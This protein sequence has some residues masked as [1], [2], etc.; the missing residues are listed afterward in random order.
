MPDLTSLRRS[1]R[2]HRRPLA[3]LLAGR[4]AARASE[5]ADANDDTLGMLYD[6]TKCVGCK[7][8]MSARKERCS[9]ASSRW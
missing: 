6:A 4:A 3:A 9:S 7:A 8:C 1:L 5:K 2:R